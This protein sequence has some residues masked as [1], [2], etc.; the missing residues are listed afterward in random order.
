[1]AERDGQLRGEF[2]VETD[3]DVPGEPVDE[4][5]PSDATTGDR[6]RRRIREGAGTVVSGRA[7]LLSLVLVAAGILLA[8]QVLPLGVIGDLLG[9][10]VGAFLYGVGSDVRHY[11]ELVLAGT[12]A[13]G[14]SALLGNLVLSLVGAG[15]PMVAFGAVAGALAAVLG[16]YF[17][18]DL[19][20]GL[21]RDL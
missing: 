13:G 3:V 17:G 12:V 14:A 2:D 5:S 10:L 18:R 4:Q 16:H 15:V 6:V 21:T 20:D 11:G 8:G 19:R 7:L 1:M 9:I